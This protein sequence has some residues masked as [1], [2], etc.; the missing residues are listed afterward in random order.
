[1]RERISFE[2]S[3]TDPKLLKNH[4]LTLSVAQQSALKIFY[5]LSLSAEELDYWSLFQGG[6]EFDNLGYPTKITPV[7]YFPKEYD[8]LVAI[9]GRRSGKTD[10][11]SATLL[12]YEAVLGGHKQYVSEKQDFIIFFIAQDVSTATSH[13]KFVSSALNSSPLLA[14]QIKNENSNGIFLTNGLSILPQP[15]TI[16]SSRGYA[17][18]VVVMD[19]VAFWYKDATSANPDF[20]VENAVEYAQQQF[21]NSKQIVTSTPWTEEGILYQAHQAGTE[22]RKLRCSQCEELNAAFCP[23]LREQRQEFAGMLVLN[24]PTASMGNPTIKKAKLAK[25]QRRKPDTFKRESLAQFT[26]SAS[27]FLPEEFVKLAIQKGIYSR[28]KFPRPDHPEDPSPI[29]IAAMDPAFRHDAFTFTILHHDPTVGIVQDRLLRL[30]PENNKPINPS[31]ALDQIKVLL[32]EFGL[33]MVYSDQYQLESLQQL[34]TLREF[35]I[36]GED[37]TAKS[38]AKIYGSLE[39]LIKQKRMRLLDHP[40]IYDELVRL[41]KKR[42]PNGTVQIGAPAGKYDDVAAVIALA[43]YQAIWMLTP[44]KAKKTI[45]PDLE[46]D[47]VKLGLEHIAKQKAAADYEGFAFGHDDD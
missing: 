10:R 26:K 2:E 16:K 6:A 23:H 4:F 33:S 37:F 22:G 9:L 41:E 20:E 38:K 8:K 12:A 30:L 3:I 17:I 29:Y 45:E 44:A 47:H 32:T 36:I 25:A 14:K 21:P 13:L 31:D 1:L 24:A 42:T 5:G 7:P 18:P 35:S 15:P 27:G 34:A 19:E 39:V 40:E 11:I 43:T 46:A 28:G